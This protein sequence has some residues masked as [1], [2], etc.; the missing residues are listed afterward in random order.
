MKNRTEKSSAA[1]DFPL[2]EQVLGI[3]APVGT[4]VGQLEEI[5]RER[6]ALFGYATNV[7]RITDI[8]KRVE[9]L[10]TELKDSPPYERIRSYMDAGNEA[11]RTSECGD[12][13]ALSA[14]YQIASKRKDQGSPLERTAHLVRSLKHP[15]EVETLR[16]VYGRGA[17]VI[18]VHVPEKDR[19][20][21]LTKD[22]GMSE[23]DARALM[24]RDE[25]EADEFGQRT[26]DAFEL[27]DAFVSLRGGRQ[28]EQLWRVLDLMFGAPHVTPT[29]SEYSMFL[30]YA[31]SLRS[32]DLSRQ[33]GA[34]V[35]S[36]DGELISTGANDV[37]RYG[38]GLYWPSDLEG[39]ELTA[40]QRDH[41]LGYDSN[42]RRRDEIVWVGILKPI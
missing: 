7:V 17:F 36:A 13:L 8:I 18:A 5:I 1:L 38:G 21:Y 25:D 24:A 10:K 39:G 26:R 22:K 4:N 29:R 33:V 12:F 20:D 19:F 35:V 34:V 14:I 37:P 28:K 32:G 15:G 40:D 9:G 31:A 11:R 3:V 6:L 27:A 2:S 16:K 41:A 23:G 42:E 30:A